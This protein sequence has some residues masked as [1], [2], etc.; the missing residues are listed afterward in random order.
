ML[1]GGRFPDES[2]GINYST[3]AGLRRSS[4]V[5]M[6]AEPYPRME[7]KLGICSEE[8]M[9]VP[10]RQSDPRDSDHRVIDF[11]T[12]AKKSSMP[13]KPVSPSSGIDRPKPK[14]TTPIDY[15]QRMMANLAAAVFAVVLAGFGVW[16]VSTLNHMRQTQDCVMMGLRNCGDTPAPHS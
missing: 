3:F 4:L 15:R 1:S 12:R 8:S 10:D 5:A 7:S 2:P 14:P 9:A 16:L 11:P 13:A 6:N